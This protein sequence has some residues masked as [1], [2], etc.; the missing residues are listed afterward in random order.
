MSLRPVF[1]LASLVHPFVQ[2]ENNVYAE[3][4]LEYLLLEG[5]LLTKIQ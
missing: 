5:E 1:T 2:V 3:F 4:E